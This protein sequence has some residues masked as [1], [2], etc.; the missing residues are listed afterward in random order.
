[1]FWDILSGRKQKLLI[2]FK[3]QTLYRIFLLDSVSSMVI[4]QPRLS[5]KIS[6]LLHRESDKSVHLQS[7]APEQW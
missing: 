3:A 2:L 1:M 6:S 5:G 4:G 7:I